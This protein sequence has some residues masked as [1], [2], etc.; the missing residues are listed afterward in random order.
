MAAYMATSV[1]MS[2]FNGLSKMHINEQAQVWAAQRL[3]DIA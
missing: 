1:A 2:N 3:C